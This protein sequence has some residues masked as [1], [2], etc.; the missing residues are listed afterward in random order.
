M[1]RLAITTTIWLALLGGGGARR[2]LCGAPCPPDG[3]AKAEESVRAASPSAAVAL[4]ENVSL[5]ED[6][7]PLLQEM[8]RRSPTFREQCR[9]IGEARHLRVKLSYA[10]PILSSR[11]R[12]LSVV[13]KREGQIDVTIKLVSSGDY[14]EMIAHEFEHV[15]EQLEGLDLVALAEQ[16]GDRAHRNELGFETR[17]ALEAGRKVRNEYLR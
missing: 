14:F 8:W 5:P 12:A 3:R 11:F 16:R 15:L 2:A 1:K 10:V 13:N 6:L 7:K 4:P 17:R 9:R